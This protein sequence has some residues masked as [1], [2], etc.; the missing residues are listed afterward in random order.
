MIAEAPL[1]PISQWQ[2]QNYQA[3]LAE[4]AAQKTALQTLAGQP[5]APSSPTPITCDGPSHPDAN[6]ATLCDRF[7]LSTFERQIIV[8]CAGCELDPQIA[9]LC[10]QLNGNPR[11]TLG[12][13]LRCFPGHSGALKPDAAL[14]YFDFIQFAADQ[15][16]FLHRPLVISDW[17]LFYLTGTGQREP[18]LNGCLQPRTSQPPVLA[19]HRSQ[20][21]HLVRWRR[22]LRTQ[23]QPLLLQ[24]KTPDLAR[25]V[26]VLVADSE[27]KMLF[28]F[29]LYHLPDAPELRHQ[30]RRWICRELVAHQALLLINAERLLNTHTDLTQDYAL[31]DWLE[32]LL[33]ELPHA[34]LL[35]ASDALHLPE[36]SVCPQTLAEATLAERIH[37][38]QCALKNTVLDNNAGLATLTALAD[39]FP[40]HAQGLQ[41]IT[42]R[43]LAAGDDA[44]AEEL[45]TRLW[46]YGREHC[47]QQLQG[48][49]QVVVP[50]DLDWQTLV[51]S[52]TEK[53]S[54]Q[55][56]VR[57]VRQRQKVYRDWG[58]AQ[59]FAYGLGMCALFAGSSGTGKTLAARIIASQ[60]GRDLYQVDLSSVMDKYIGETEKNLEKIFTAAE[61]SGAV[62]LFDE[63]DALFG[64]R[65]KVE[66]AK[67]RYAN[68]GVSYLLQRLEQYNGL[69]ILTTNLRS[70]IDSA[71]SRRLRFIINFSFPSAPERAR[72]WR[73]VLPADAPTAALD[74]TKLARLSLAG[75]AIRNITLQAAFIA[76][77]Q[78]QPMNMMHFLEAVK[79]DYL[80]TEKTLDSS[81]V[82]D[83]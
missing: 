75:G 12:L 44:T 58:F 20:A 71:F 17:L 77:D 5:A 60:L 8:L 4:I 79:E 70:A 81:L 50:G 37:S 10:Q 46:Q 29:N 19:S 40:L 74:F 41:A 30:Y 11:P 57:Q 47:R 63:A 53:K 66:D 7:R 2:Q 61:R 76:A 48:L 65:T 68:S 1:S 16:T 64:K 67:D 23:P 62:L 28:E 72:L 27:H 18:G 38:W 22:A 26:A 6:M 32:R 49:A 42:A 13:A 43:A 24:S 39:H 31:R 15:G 82:H 80:K 34:C 9:E 25:Q 73:S 21:Q 54:L 78:G 36:I 56:I 52:E 59:H 45:H 14:R 83:W 33:A 51:L 35:S 69:S 55:A 3:L